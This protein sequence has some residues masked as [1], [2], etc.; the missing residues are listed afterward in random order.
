MEV[1][2][3]VPDTNATAVHR[4]YAAELLYAVGRARDAY[5]EFTTDDAL[6]VLTYHSDAYRAYGRS[7][8]IPQARPAELDLL[9][10]TRRVTADGGVEM[11]VRGQFNTD[12]SIGTGK[13]LGRHLDTATGDHL[14][15]VLD[16][17]RAELTTHGIEVVPSRTRDE[18]PRGDPLA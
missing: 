10:G 2:D 8:F 3:I 4:D 9:E 13:I 5:E 12:V 17:L 11:T 18:R 14:A 7:A 15:A 16:A 6:A 1:S